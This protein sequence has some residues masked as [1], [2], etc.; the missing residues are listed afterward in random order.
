MLAM[1]LS[2]DVTDVEALAIDRP[3]PADISSCAQIHRT[4]WWGEDS[5]R[6]QPV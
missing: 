4:A 1:L 3:G 2:A 6:L 5:N